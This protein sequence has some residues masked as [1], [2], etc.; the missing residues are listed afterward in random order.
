MGGTTLSAPGG[1]Y[2]SETAWIYTGGGQSWTEP[3]PSYQVG[4]QQS[5]WREMPDVAF[6]AD[7]NTGVAVYDS[8]D[9][10]QSTPWETVGGTSVGAPCWAGLIAIA[11]QLR[12]SRGL[13]SLDG[14]SQT[15]P[16]LYGLPAADFHDITSGNYGYPA[17]PGYDMY[18]C[19]GTPVANSLVPALAAWSA[20]TPLVTSTSSNNQ[21]VFGQSVTFTASVYAPPVTGTATGTVTFRDGSLILCT[22]PLSSNGQASFSTSALTTGVHTITVSYGGDSQL[23]ANATIVTETVS[24]DPTTTVVTTSAST[25][26]FG[27]S[28]TLTATVTAA[29]S[30]PEIPTGTVSFMVGNTVVGTATLS[31]GVARCTTGSLPAGTDVVTAVYSGDGVNFSGSTSAPVGPASIITTVAGNGLDGCNGDGGPATAA[32]LDYPYSVAVDSAGDLFMA[33]DDNRIRE[34]NHATGV[35]TTVAG[36]GTCGYSGDGGQA[37]EAQ[38]NLCGSSI[39]VDAAGDVFIA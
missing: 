21:P 38:L 39:A 18:T 20:S 30:S 22:A 27:Q 16:A 25:L 17:G 33:E 34:V 24:P 32:E 28:V 26:T 29:P 1:V 14:P 9:F 3:E 15:L 35:I 23:P 8:Y 36:N 5:G 10:G 7:P 12:G 19:L 31:G 4:V 11:D 6:D 37:T 2:G 13:P